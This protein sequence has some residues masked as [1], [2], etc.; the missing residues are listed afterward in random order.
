MSL[1]H[2]LLNG[3]LTPS[4]PHLPPPPSS[5]SLLFL[6]ALTAI[7]LL[8]PF[9]PPSSANSSWPPSAVA[10]EQRER[11]RRSSLQSEHPHTSALCSPLL[12]AARAFTCRC[13]SRARTQTHVSTLYTISTSTN[14]H[15]HAKKHL[16]R[17]DTVRNV[18]NC[19]TTKT[20][21]FTQSAHIISLAA[22]KCQMNW[23]GVYCGTAIVD[24][25]PR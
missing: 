11:A 10:A 23:P 12:K 18:S 9:D 7:S 14:Q 8:L 2:S 20:L 13:I 22:G 16:I 24:L 17:L 3:S 15:T 6:L 4:L 5:I 1:L 25:I 19:T 21:F